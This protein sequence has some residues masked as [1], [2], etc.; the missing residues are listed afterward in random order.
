M[1][2]NLSTTTLGFLRGAGQE[3]DPYKAGTLWERAYIRS[4]HPERLVSQANI[5]LLDNEEMIDEE[6]DMAIRVG[7]FDNP[8]PDDDFLTSYNE[9]H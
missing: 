9:Q 2:A 4:L 1:Q 7:E 6:L 8:L 3:D 5:E